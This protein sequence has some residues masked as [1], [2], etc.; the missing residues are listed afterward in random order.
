[1]GSTWV[2]RYGDGVAR[3]DGVFIFHAKGPLHYHRRTAVETSQ[4]LR[5]YIVT[6]GPIIIII[7]IIVIFIITS[8]S[9][10]SFSVDW[11]VLLE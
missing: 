2:G 11:I 3:A 7:I 8:L 1:M 4:I 5:M 6:L 9:L 10:A